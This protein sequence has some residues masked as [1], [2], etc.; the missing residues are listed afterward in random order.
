M[1]LS[2]AQPAMGIVLLQ[3]GKPA[4]IFVNHFGCSVRSVERLRKKVRDVGFERGVM[5]SPR[6]G[7]PRVVLERDITLMLALC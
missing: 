1:K 5:E 3:A 6:S 7:R 2:P 4:I